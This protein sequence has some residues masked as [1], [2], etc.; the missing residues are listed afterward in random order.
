MRPRLQRR[1]LALLAGR[2]ARREPD[3][4]DSAS[5][6]TVALPDPAMRSCR[7]GLVIPAGAVLS[8]SQCVS[9]DVA[10]RLIVARLLKERTVFEAYRQA[11]RRE[12]VRAKLD[13]GISHLKEVARLASLLYDS[14]TQSTRGPTSTIGLDADRVLCRLGI[15][16]ELGLS[17]DGVATADRRRMLEEMIPPG[18]RQ[19]LLRNLTAHGKQV[20]RAANASCDSCEIRN[21]C[22]TYRSEQVRRT[23]HVMSLR[24]STSSPAQADFRGPG[25][26]GLSVLLRSIVTRWL[27][28][29]T[30]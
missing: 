12:S 27:C 19:K 18:L 4:S 10:G 8:S 15:Y 11:N 29:L 9:P 16:R 14:T 3:V 17:V 2:R 30:H 5:C 1:H 22:S 23:D 6:N 21:F 7:T 20:C 13:D 26:S 28:G 24:L 25:T